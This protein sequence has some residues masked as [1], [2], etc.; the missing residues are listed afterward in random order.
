M[1]LMRRSVPALLI[2]LF[3]AVDLSA[4]T[5]ITPSGNSITLSGKILSA[6]NNPVAGATVAVKGSKK[7]A[8]AA[9]DGSFSIS[10]N[11]PG[12]G[13]NGTAGGKNIVL[14]VSAIGVETTEMN[15][16]PESPTSLSIA[17]KESAKGL[18]EVVVI[19][20]GTQRKRDVTGAVGS[21]QLAN[22]DRTPVFGTSQLL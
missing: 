1:M 6:G 13:G 20:Y 5:Q 3:L 17:L 15:L 16:P 8:V 21:V 10:M 7:N 9:A 14:V 2:L 11:V 22:V 19:G 18:N 4:Q 12:A